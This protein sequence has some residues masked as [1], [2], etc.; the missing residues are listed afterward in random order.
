M[1]RSAADRLKLTGTSEPVPVPRRLVAG[2][3]E[4]DFVDAGLRAIRWHGVE[5]LRAIAYIVRDRDWGT[6]AL[7][8]ADLVVEELDSGI[9]VSYSATCR[10]NEGAVLRLAAAIE[11]D[12][13]GRLAFTVEATPDAAFETNRCGFCILHP[14]EGLAGRPVTVTQTDGTVEQARFPE[15]IEPWQP[16]KDMRA[17]AHELAPGLRAVVTMTGDRFEMEDQRAWTDASYKTYVRPLAEPWPYRLPAGKTDRQAV[18][19]SIDGDRGGVPA[20]AVRPGAEG[21]SL[22]LAGVTDVFLPRIGVAVAP[23]EVGQAL[24]AAERLAD[25]APRHLLLHFDPTAGHGARELAALAALAHVLPG[26]P[27]M[28]ECVVPG[29]DAPAVELPRLAA[30]VGASALRPA[31]IVVGPSVDRQSTPPG[32]AWPDCPPLE[33]IYEAAREVFPGVA[34][35][36]GMF[37]YFTELNRKRVPVAHLD[38]VT[39]ATCPIVHAADDASVMQS[40][41]SLPFVTASTRAFVGDTPYHLG[42]TTIGM[43]QNPYGSRTMDNPQGRRI[44]MAHDDP[45]QRGLFAAAWL[46]G[47][48]A[49]LAGGEVSSWTGASFAGP[50]G[51]LAGGETVV[52]AFHVARALADLSGCRRRTLA[53]SGRARIDGFA[54]MRADGD[55]EVWLANLTAEAQAFRMDARPRE[56]WCLDLA[57]FDAAAGGRLPQGDPGAGLI[58]PYAVMRFLVAS[59]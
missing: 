18:T 22:S 58:G 27:A 23:E 2:P 39:H 57:G 41:E 25:L 47:Y 55:T 21:V 29:V 11:A 46:T 12:A 30:L 3:L 59:S 38:F 45:R 17:I 13:G 7:D 43:R 20:P 26:V 28:L 10:S 51:L 54:A 34:L 40:L 49:R 8:I 48:A 14:I 52:P 35:G 9:R 16:F 56:A 32:S 31:A 42:P 19:L 37:S 33:E 6:Y 53:S 1:A 4:A 5:V 24:A 36:G 15:R 44:A 50:R